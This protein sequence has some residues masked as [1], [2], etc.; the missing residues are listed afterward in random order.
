MKK[1]EAWFQR[2]LNDDVLSAVSATLIE[3]DIRFQVLEDE[4]TGHPVC[5]FFKGGMCMNSFAKTSLCNG[6]YRDPCPLVKWDKKEIVSVYCE[7][8]AHQVLNCTHSM[9]KTHRCDGVENCFIT[10]EKL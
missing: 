2:E 6:L 7:F 9:S 8:Y 3:H 1:L 4:R 5:D 10:K